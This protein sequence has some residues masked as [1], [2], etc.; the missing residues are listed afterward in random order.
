M[1]ILSEEIN[2]CFACGLCSGAKNRVVG[3]GPL[4]ANLV[5]VGEAPGRRENESGYPFV[6]SAGK[7]LDSILLKA[8]LTRDQIY[9][10]NI[11]KCRPPMN[12]KPRRDEVKAC[13]SHLEKQ[14]EIIK[15]KI[16][17]PMG[18]SATKF[19]FEKYNIKAEAISEAHGKTKKVEA[20]WGG[21]TLFP[22]YHPAAAIYNRRLLTELEKDLISLK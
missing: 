22:L 12:R 10:T 15:P 9:I 7:L 17:A 1:T 2:Q 13:C 8:E 19:F 11:L 20:T 6:G 16:I 14:L 3:K 21:I 5:L 4:N 18:N